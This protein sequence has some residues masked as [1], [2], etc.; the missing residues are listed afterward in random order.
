MKRTQLVFFFGTST[1]VSKS[2]A[3]VQIGHQQQ[4]AAYVVGV[5]INTVGMSIFLLPME[6]LHFGGK[7]LHYS[8][9]DDVIMLHH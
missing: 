8:T 2:C 9:F 1:D 4:I 3:V 5:N 6:V 7:Y